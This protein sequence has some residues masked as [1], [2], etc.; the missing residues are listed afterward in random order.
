MFFDKILIANRGEVAVRIIRAC[1]ELGIAAI[2]VYSTA[3]RSAP[4]VRMA[5]AAYSIGPAAAAE[6]YLRIERI[7]EAALQ[8]GAQAIHPG[9]GFL[10]ERA[11]FA[12]ACREAGLVFIGPPPE[13][14]DLMGSKIAAKRLADASGVPTVPGYLGDDQLPATLRRAATRIGFPLL[15]KASAGGGGKGLRVVGRAS[16]FDA[17][18]EAAQR[19]ARAAF[20]D[21][22]VLLE[23][24]IPRPRHVEI[25][26][27]ADAHGNCVHLFER[28]CSI[29]RRH[30]KIVEESPSVAL[31]PEL[32]AEMG[33]AAVRLAQAA[34]YRNAGTVEFMLGEAGQ[35][36]FLEMN[37]RLQVEHPVTEL[38]VG[39]DLVRL[40]IAIAA[41]ERLLF[42]QA[43]LSQRGHAIEVRVYA[44]DPATYLPATGRVALFAPPE[45]P[46]IR[47]DAGIASGDEITVHYDPLIAKLIV[48]A[49][50]RAAALARLRQALDDYAVLGVTTN[51]PLLQAIAAHPDFAACATHTDFL[52]AS[53]LDG[54][55]FKPPAPP[56]EA[57]VAAAIADLRALCGDSSA[58]TAARDGQRSHSDPW[59]VGPWRMLRDGMRLRYISGAVEH[60]ANVSRVADH[61]RVE[62][63]ETISVVGLVAERPG[64]LVLEFD[65]GSIERFAVACDGAD[66]LVGWRGQS[67]RLARAAALSV[68][69]IGRRAGGAPGHA[70]LAAPMP[71]TVIKVLAAEGQVVVASQPLVILEAMKMEHIVAAPYDGVVRR[72]LCATGALVARG[73]TLV[74]LD[75]GRQDD[76]MTR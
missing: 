56:P 72:V 42:G 75:E 66:R 33:A 37:T 10:A 44:E 21:D 65:G 46:G 35:Y 11:P 50:D 70:S 67:F 53:G 32:R 71:G 48:Y 18:L 64:Q 8:G 58:A 31:S 13:A 74:E 20:G 73:A 63:G 57:L 69:T 60:T 76:K 40:Q 15:I 62:V 52:T 19:E 59:S 1:H 30:Q 27:L 49:P 47:N 24:L 9:Y 14:I 39:V 12:R 28:E 43:D 38:V 7:I 17:A 3:D 25:Q 2:A 29:Q 45:G 4:H 16:E 6:S 22:A 54:A 5:D 26:V 61:W 55:S 51:L 41:G 34:G 68:D 23:R 36:Y